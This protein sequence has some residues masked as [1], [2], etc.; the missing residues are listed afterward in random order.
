MD[1]FSG[2][3]VAE[4]QILGVQGK[5]SVAGEAGNIFKR[6]A[7]WAVERIACQGM[8]DR[9]QMDSDLMGAARI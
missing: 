7:G 5:S 2:D 4:F 6:L 8:A 1:W 9:C 3:G